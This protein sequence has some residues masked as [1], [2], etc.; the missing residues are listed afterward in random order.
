[1]NV[2]MLV[3]ILAAVLGRR[4]TVLLANA[5]LM[6][7]ALAMPLGGNYSA[8]RHQRRR[9]ARPCTRSAS[10]R[11]V[12]A[13]LL[14][15]FINVGILLSYVSNY[16]L[17]RL[18]V[19][20]GWRVMFG[21]GVVP[22]VLFA[23]GC[24]PCAAATATRTRCWCAP[25]TL[26]RRPMAVTGMIGLQFFQQASDIDAIVLYSLPLVFKHAGISSNTSVLAAT[27]AIGVVKRCFIR[28]HAPLRPPQPSPASPL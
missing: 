21:L 17:A 2:F 10:T 9:Q 8:F 7:G 14:D 26:S 23:A 3:S 19:H 13:S 28:R 22:P 12:L 4:G 5:F 27:V 15:M 18:P 25:P 11:G 6:A 20:L 16:A 24:S 1:M